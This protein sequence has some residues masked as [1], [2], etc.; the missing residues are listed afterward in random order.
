MKWKVRVGWKGSAWET[1]RVREAR[2]GVRD[3][4][5]PTGFV[6]IWWTR[7]FT[8]SPLFHS[9]SAPFTRNLCPEALQQRRLLITNSSCEHLLSFVMFLETL[10][11]FFFSRRRSVH[12]GS[13]VGSCV[14]P[15]VKWR[16]SAGHFLCVR[17]PVKVTDRVMGRQTGSSAS[18]DS[19]TVYQKEKHKRLCAKQMM[20]FLPSTHAMKTFSLCLELKV[21]STFCLRMND[22][23]VLTQH[24]PLRS[25]NKT[26][27]CFLQS[28]DEPSHPERNQI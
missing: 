8:D 24:G 2:R 11:A 10:L 18:A 23:N 16:W 17:W 25:H 22:I 13:G 1:R 6:E 26:T 9:F 19:L 27:L 4:C 15:C 14:K 5:S 28:H 20:K 7:D 3:S 21:L 12:Y